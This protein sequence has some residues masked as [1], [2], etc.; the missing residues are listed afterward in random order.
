MFFFA[1]HIQ[2]HEPLWP[3]RML[4]NFLREE[5]NHTQNRANHGSVSNLVSSNLSRGDNHTRAAPGEG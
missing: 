5:T 1:K 4:A 2:S 3:A